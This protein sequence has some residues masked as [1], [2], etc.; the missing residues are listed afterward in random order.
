M[1]AAMFADIPLKLENTKVLQAVRMR[2]FWLASSVYLICIPLLW[3]S[4][5]VGLIA[6]DAALVATALMV[7]VNAG[8]YWAFRSGLN[9]RAKADPSLTWLQVVAA[10]AVLMFA[11]YSFDKNRALVLLLCLVVLVFG[12]FRFT[13]REYVFAAMVMLAGYAGVINVAMWRKPDTVDVWVEAVQ[14]LTLAALL[15]AFG[16]IGG[17]ISDLRKR[18]RKTNDELGT[19]LGTIQRMASH[20]SLTGLPNRVLFSET[21]DHALSQAERHKHPVALLFMD[22]DRFKNINDTLGHPVGDRVLQ[23]AA[24]RIAGAVRDSDVVARLGGDE[25]VVLIE[26]FRGNEDLAEVAAKLIAT[27]TAPFEIDGHSLGLSASIGICTYPNDAGNALELV[28][29][30]DAAMY[31]A[32]DL[33]PGGYCFYSQG[34]HERSVDRLELE[35]DLRHAAEKGELR[36]HY[37]PKLDMATGR[38]AGVEALLRW[39]HP[40][41]GLM[42]P[43]KFIG[44]AEET[45]LIVPIGYWTVDA[46]CRQALSWIAKGHAAIPVAVNLSA[47][48]FRQD[49]LAERL[50]A[51]LKATGYPAERLE[52]EITESMVMRD[53]DAATETMKRLRAMG[54]RLSMDDFGTGYSSL[55][56]L[57]RFPIQSLKVDRSFVRDLPHNGDD[58][59]ITRAVIAMAHSLR[60][61]V[62]AEGVEHQ[63]QFDALLREGCDKYQGY[64]CRP[65]LTETDLMTYLEDER[66][67]LH[68]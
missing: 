23:L 7:A 38:I 45:G 1:R 46:V 62:V 63:G 51:I 22:L 18:L 39:Q 68:P 26:N 4:N 67:V 41:W 36:I 30:S 53:P 50:G 16:L 14:W 19:A 60:M 9:L 35:A 57:K 54:I 66:K 59:A 24:R 8:F 65:P 11:A 55:G 42:L 32:K 44:L 25:Y 52:L 27:L 13:L 3:L 28:A 20:D 6:R 31:R 64:F 47:R 34:Q 48:Q 17:R 21:L 61:D 56:V 12:V 49:D 40:R 2:R 15:P 29:N 58:V 33:N 5:A 43:E 10:T 37:Q